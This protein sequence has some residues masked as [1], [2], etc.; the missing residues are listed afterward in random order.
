[1][2]EPLY[3]RY[4][5]GGDHVRT[6]ENGLRAYEMLFEKYA[7]T[8]ERYPAYASRLRVSMSLA[9]LKRGRR[10]EARR[11]AWRAI[12]LHPR[13]LTAYACLG[14]SFVE[15]YP[16]LSS[17]WRWWTGRRAAPPPVTPPSRS[18]RSGRGLARSPHGD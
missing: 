4:A 9:H 11:E 16:A 18:S 1:V 7:A 10:R 8:F 5:H 2:P 14:L 17:L 3:L 12:A 6:P 15:L 13:R